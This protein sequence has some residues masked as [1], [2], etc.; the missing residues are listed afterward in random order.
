MKRFVKF[1]TALENRLKEQ[2]LSKT[3]I[4]ESPV[5]W[6]KPFDSLTEAEK[7]HAWFTNRSAKYVGTIRYWKA[8]AYNPVT[9]KLLITTEE[10]KSKFTELYAVY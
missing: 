1:Q 4:T 9:T 7:R 5:K 10:G 2:A 6:G 8:V 3:E